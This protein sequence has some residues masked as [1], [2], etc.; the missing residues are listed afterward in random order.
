MLFSTDVYVR[1]KK[2][3]VSD[4]YVVPFNPYLMLKYQGHLNVEIC[5]SVACF[6]YLYKYIFKGMRK[7]IYYLILL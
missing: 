2:I 6:K 4:D 5:T 1:G 3:T 7:K